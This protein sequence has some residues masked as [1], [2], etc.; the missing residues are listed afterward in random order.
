MRV[1][2]SA[3]GTRVAFDDPNLIAFPGL[4]LTADL[5]RKVDLAALIDEKVELLPGPGAANAAQKGMSLLGGPLAGGDC[6]D[7][8]DVL[9]AGNAPSVLGHQLAALS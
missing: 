6:I 4:Q 8:V 3:T 9:R 5:A 1:P 7:D 2:H